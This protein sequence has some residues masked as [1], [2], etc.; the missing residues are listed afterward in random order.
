[1]GPDSSECVVKSMIV[2]VLGDVVSPVSK[3]VFW[4]SAGV[5]KDRF[6]VRD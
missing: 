4:G 2:E 5:R 1:M 6:P 3:C